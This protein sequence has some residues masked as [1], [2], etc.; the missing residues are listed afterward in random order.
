MAAARRREPRWRRAGCAA[1]RSRN[2]SCATLPGLRL[3]GTQGSAEF[4]CRFETVVREKRKRSGQN[5]L[6]LR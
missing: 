4:G 6:K 2:G 5:R 1:G 3:D